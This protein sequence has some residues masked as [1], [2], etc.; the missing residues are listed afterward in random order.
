M[1]KCPTCPKCGS[2]DTDCYD[3]VGGYGTELEE[4]M[5]CY[6]CG[7]QYRLKYQLVEVVLD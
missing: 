1:L 3:R 6:D 5:H 7:I 2:E 4:L